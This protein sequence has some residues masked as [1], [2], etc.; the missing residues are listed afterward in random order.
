MSNFTIYHNPR[1]SKS[2][3]TLTLLEENGITPTVITY[4]DN[5]PSAKELKS[6]LRQLDL[7]P[8]DLMRKTESAYTTAGL[9]NENL[10]DS[11][12]IA[13]MVSHPILIER[14]IVTNGKKA[15]LGRPPKNVLELI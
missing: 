5:P 14:P 7:S 2:R 11:E 3:Q 4:L 12:L 15:V 6:L 1:C 8:R 13:A 9:K 10:T